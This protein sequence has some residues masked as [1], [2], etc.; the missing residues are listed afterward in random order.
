[1]H[2]GREEEA[3]GGSSVLAPACRGLLA[4]GRRGGRQQSPGVA[5]AGTSTPVGRRRPDRARR[6]GRGLVLVPRGDARCGRGG[7]EAGRPERQALRERWAAARAQEA[8]GADW[9]AP[10]GQDVWQ[11]TASTLCG[12]EGAGGPRVARPLLAAEGD[13]PIFA[14]SQAIIGDGNAAE[15]GG[16]RGEDLGAGAGWVAMG[17]PALCPDPGR[18]MRAETGSGQRRLARAPAEHREGVDGHQPISLGGGRA[19]VRRRAP[20]P[21]QARGHAQAEGTPSARVQVGR[22]PT[23]PPWPP[24]EWGARAEACKAAVEVCT[25]RV[26]RDCWCERATGRRASGSVKGTRT[27]GPGKRSARCGARQDVASSFWHLGPCRCWQAWERSSSS[28]HAVPW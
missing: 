19:P 26:E 9:D 7:A 14:G 18:H 25:S 27:Y 8:V 28:P 6:A 16:A 22:L 23:R 2:A 1:M 24:R 15:R 5:D 4:C 13:V 10:L 3:R 20:A 12:G 17:S 21:R 11:E